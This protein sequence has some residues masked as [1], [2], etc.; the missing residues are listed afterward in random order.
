MNRFFGRRNEV[1]KSSPSK[2]NEEGLRA[3]PER[4]R[5][6]EM[7][8]FGG[9][10]YFAPEHEVVLGDKR[11][12][13]PGHSNDSSDTRYGSIDKKSEKIFPRIE[14]E[15][16][17]CRT[18][19]IVKENTLKVKK[20]ETYGQ[21]TL[22]SSNQSA[23]DSSDEYSVGGESPS[24]AKSRKEIAKTKARTSNQS[25][26]SSNNDSQEGNVEYESE[27]NTSPPE[28]RKETRTTHQSSMKKNH[29][30]DNDTSDDDLANDE[31]KLPLAKG[32][33]RIF[34]TDKHIRDK[35]SEGKYPPAKPAMGQKCR[36]EKNKKHQSSVQSTIKSDLDTSDEE[37]TPSAKTQTNK[38][39]NQSS[40]DTYK[41]HSDYDSQED[42]AGELTH[43]KG[44]KGRKEKNAKHHPTVP[45][46]EFD[47]QEDRDEYTPPAHRRKVNSQNLH[48]HRDLGRSSIFASHGSQEEYQVE[49]KPHQNEENKS[50]KVRKA[51]KRNSRA[52]GDLHGFL[53]ND[54]IASPLKVSKHE[55]HNH[56]RS[57]LL[58][59][60]RCANDDQES[61]PAPSKNKITIQG[62][63][64][65]VT[66]VH[67]VQEFAGVEQDKTKQN[68]EG[69]RTKPSKSKNK[70]S[71]P[72]PWSKNLGKI[73]NIFKGRA[74][75]GA[76]GAPMSRK[77][78][79][80]KK[81]CKAFLVSILLAAFVVGTFVSLYFLAVKFGDLLL[82]TRIA[83]FLKRNT[84]LLDSITSLEKEQTNLE[85]TTK[86]FRRYAGALEESN[87]VY[88][89]AL[90]EYA[91]INMEVASQLVTL[92]NLA[93]QYEKMSAES[94]QRLKNLRVVVAYY[95]RYIAEMKAAQA[96][97][98]SNLK[99][100]SSRLM[101]YRRLNIATYQNA[102]QLVEL[103]AQL[104]EQNIAWIGY[105]KKINNTL[106]DRIKAVELMERVFNET[107]AVNESQM[108]VLNNLNASLISMSD[109][110]EIRQ[111]SIRDQWDLIHSYDAMILSA[112]NSKALTQARIDRIRASIDRVE[113][114]KTKYGGSGVVYYKMSDAL[115]LARM[116]AIDSTESL[117][118][119]RLYTLSCKERDYFESDW[120][121][122][123]NA[124]IYPDYDQLV[125][126]VENHLFSHVC[127][128]N[129][130]DFKQ[131]V[132]KKYPTMTPST[133]RYVEFR[134]AYT[135]YH[136]GILAHLFPNPNLNETGRNESEWVVADFK[137]T[138]LD[139]SV[140]FTYVGSHIEPK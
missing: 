85:K 103:T 95:E 136:S 39:Q 90:S 61:S 10:L 35:D 44:I 38:E 135:V 37:I 122:N 105:M 65:D 69:K 115:T 140:K 133:L 32:K 3:L 125:I 11:M 7:L 106:A 54:D 18:S 72:K 60:N 119:R 21:S 134:S 104:K 30:S 94:E 118:K 87:R 127:T 6:R 139:P 62:T 100:I 120:V 126:F 25:S 22:M 77:K 68:T 17:E 48:P 82:Q 108:R 12:N 84:N 63:R 20:P 41:S 50:P 1:E 74:K 51:E 73:K 29:K 53:G 123:T 67:E 5:T 129:M 27:E 97:W 128:H 59:S 47:S 28:V 45:R 113:E 56:R 98:I 13:L 14:N 132:T 130:T 49:S 86:N 116:N 80:L 4:R 42:S 8:S 23:D 117:M 52:S 124:K 24:P 71:K 16:Q 111:A 93:I 88:R 46:S 31:G 101:Y 92:E 131:F 96:K 81:C 40:S 121:W 102:N 83:R 19:Q 114:Y 107:E 64:Q 33:N 79:L 76:K 2:K 78:E 43:V 138:N 89:N 55:D 36:T 15:V 70:P 75:E 91:S 34:S 26:H 137:C 66:D 57:T 58:A 109:S 110:I 9:Y 112:Q 99:K